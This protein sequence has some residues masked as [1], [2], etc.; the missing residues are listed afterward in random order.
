MS[1]GSY[2]AVLNQGLPTNKI[3]TIVLAMNLKDEI[4]LL[5]R[6][7][8]RGKHRCHL[9]CSTPA[10]PGMQQLISR[11]RIAITP[12]STSR[13][14]VHFPGA[15]LNPLLELYPSLK[16]VISCHWCVWWRVDRLSRTRQN[17]L[18]WASLLTRSHDLIFHKELIP[19]HESRANM[20]FCKHILSWVI[21]N[22][23]G[24]RYENRPPQE[25][26]REIGNDVALSALYSI[27]TPVQFLA[28][29]SSNAPP[30][31]SMFFSP[32]SSSES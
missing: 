8:H 30:P 16:H 17:P 20:E 7:V 4:N 15:S 5:E 2:G 26:H 23:R 29:V 14:P 27:Y 11:R 12:H 31:F 24:M 28:P 25:I 6:I 9:A 21:N 10:R 18:I 19:C 22:F 32:D 3:T 1:M 13:F